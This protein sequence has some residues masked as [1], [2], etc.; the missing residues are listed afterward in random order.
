MCALSIQSWQQSRAVA[1]QH[2]ARA[3]GALHVLRMTT[4]VR[5]AV[6]VATAIMLAVAR[7]SS[8]QLES[9]GGA[10]ARTR[11][12]ARVCCQLRTSTAQASHPGFVR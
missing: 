1:Q 3:G 7:V 5:G 6:V 10:R 4:R 8:R 11:A 9:A 2:L 12:R